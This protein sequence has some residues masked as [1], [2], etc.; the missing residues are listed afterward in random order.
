MI[1]NPL[2]LTTFK[3]KLREST[4]PPTEFWAE[5]PN[6]H[7][8]LITLTLS[9]TS[10]TST[11]ILKGG[12]LEKSS[13]HILEDFHSSRTIRRLVLDSPT[14]ASILFKKALSGVVGS[15][16]LVSLI[17]SLIYPFICKQESP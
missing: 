14:F 8:G 11:R 5:V 17:T 12:C 2:V 9:A 6:N 3:S 16:T 1:L 10:I 7:M 15:R 4:C 13:Q